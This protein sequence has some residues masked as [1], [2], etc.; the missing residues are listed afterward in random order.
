MA[1]NNCEIELRLDTSNKNNIIVRIEK[2]NEHHHIK[3]VY[4]N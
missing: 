4:K 2:S 1:K 3:G